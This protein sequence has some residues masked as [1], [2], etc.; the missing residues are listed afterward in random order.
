MNDSSTR[1][2]IAQVPEMEKIVHLEEQK[3]FRMSLTSENKG[4]KSRKFAVLQYE[5][6]EPGVYDL[7]HTEGKKKLLDD[8]TVTW[9]T[10]L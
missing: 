8:K 6:I 4:S 5:E 2:K 10:W 7:Y 9:I 1:P 3:E